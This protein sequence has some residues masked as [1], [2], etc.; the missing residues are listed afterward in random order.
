MDLHIRQ[1]NDR[2]DLKEFIF[3][4]EKIH[5]NHHPWVPPL[6]LHE[7]QYFDPRKNLDFAYCDRVLLLASRG[8]EMVGRIMGIINHRYNEIR[9]ERTARFAYLETWEDDE[10]VHALL[11]G[12]E[13]WARN[14][15]MTKIIGPY[16]FSDQDPEGFL[17]EGFEH[18]ATIG[19]YCN[20]EW[21]A[22]FVESAGYSKEIDY[23]TYRMDV[24]QEKSELHKRIAVYERVFERVCRRGNFE[25]AEFGTKKAA[26]QWAKPVFRLMNECYMDSGI[27]GY[28][29]LTEGEMDHL[30]K[31]YLPLIDPR[32]LKLIR[33]GNDAV[34]FIIGIPDMTEGLQKAR[35]RL[36]PMGFLKI[37]RARNKA[38][39]LDLLLGA[40]KE[41]Y[42]GLGLD[43]LLVVKMGLSAY[44][45]GMEV[46]DTHHVMETNNKMRQEYERLG[47]KIY[48]RFRVYQKSL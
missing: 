6:Y 24:P 27:Y 22:R 11:A 26:T 32:F 2:S 44:E 47:G 16:G 43:G 13:D 45:A 19:T 38:K 28:N 14:K 30:L 20:F 33:R 31:R 21:M 34:G 10:I 17:I 15:G 39:Q 48:K 1:V 46:V 29:P 36:F 4:P 8:K 37:F 23:V 42:R 25:I 5:A 12:V 41:E 35:G 9:D 7:W 3:L 18:R 40:I